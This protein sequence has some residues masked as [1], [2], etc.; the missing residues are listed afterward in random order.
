MSEPQE[1]VAVACPSCSPDLDTVHE[2]LTTGG[3]HATVP[4][5][6]VEFQLEADGVVLAATE[7]HPFVSEA[8]RYPPQFGLACCERGG[9]STQ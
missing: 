6:E 4:G 5:V 9:Y 3:G 2:V 7:T 8:H 1:R